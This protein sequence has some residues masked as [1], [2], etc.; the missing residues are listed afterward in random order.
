MLAKISLDHYYNI[1]NSGDNDKQS[2]IKIIFT[3][4]KYF[5]MI[6]L[7]TLEFF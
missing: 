3:L 2:S 7:S 4:N 6:K 1:T 5:L